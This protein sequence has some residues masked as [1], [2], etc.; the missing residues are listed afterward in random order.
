MGGAGGVTPQVAAVRSGGGGGA[1]KSKRAT[2]MNVALSP[3]END[4]L[5]MNIKQGGEAAYNI[6]ELPDLDGKSFSI[7]SKEISNIDMTLIVLSSFYL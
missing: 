3:M 1:T 7:Y 6:H 2:T 5:E 4:L